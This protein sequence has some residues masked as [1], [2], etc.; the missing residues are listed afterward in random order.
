MNRVR[1]ISP[2]MDADSRKRRN[3]VV[4]PE[5]DRGRLARHELGSALPRWQRSHRELERFRS[6]EELL[7]RLLA[8]ALRDDDGP[9]RSLLALAPEE[10]L[11]ARL[12]LAAV[13][14][15]LR[16]QAGWIA[17]HRAHVSAGTRRLRRGLGAPLLPR[18]GGDL[19]RFCLPASAYLPAAR[20]RDPLPDA[21]GA[22]P[23]RAA[24][25]PRPAGAARG[26][27]ART[28]RPRRRHRAAAHPPAC[29]PNRPR[30]RR[31]E[32]VADID[33]ERRP[34]PMLPGRPRLC[35]A[36]AYTTVTLLTASPPAL[37]ATDLNTVIGNLELWL[38]GLLASL[39]TVFLIIGAV[40]YVDGRRRPGPARE[41]KERDH[42]RGARLR[43]RALRPGRDHDHPADRR[44]MTRRRLAIARR[45]ACAWRCS[46]PLPR[47][48]PPP[49]G[50]ADRRRRP[51]RHDA[52]GVQVG[53][54]PPSS[55]GGGQ[56]TTVPGDQATQPAFWDL[57]GRVRQA[58]DDWFSGLVLDALTPT[59]A[60]VGKTVLSTPALGRNAQIAGLWQ[61]SLI[62]ADSLLVLFL[63]VGAGLAMSHETLQTPL[64]AQGPAARGSPSPAIVINASLSLVDQLGG[65]A[66]ALA[67]AF[68]GDGASAAGGR[69][70]RSRASSSARSPAAASSSRCSG[71][72][73]PSPR[74]R[75]SSLYL[76]R[77][78][79]VVVL[80]CA[81]PARSC[82]RHLFP[83]TEG[84]AHLWWRAL[85]AAF[86]VQVSQA[87]LLAA[88]VRVFFAGGGAGPRPLGRRQRRSTCC[89]ASA[90]STCS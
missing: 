32:P 55:T 6:P 14:P 23:G 62:A 21:D 46:G 34:R 83:Q 50:A 44:R 78:A 38:T 29:P 89:S 80:V 87:L 73:A 90:C 76:L 18:L 8:D 12:V 88:C 36:L 7:A 86:G 11:A 42:E 31:P 1:M 51:G 71:S 25:G 74:S 4:E 3:K 72:P 79:I 13:L 64:R 16:Q 49:A 66:N 81:A 69:A 82:S 45:A 58:I 52:P 75:C 39:A 68:L 27:R 84:L 17:C 5:R 53:P 43:L 35:A 20:R 22:R 56:T 33:A 41:G 28:A 26:R 19:L 60:L 70:P 65:V 77:A 40:R 10:P 24:R 57:P 37:A 48:P 15:A 67:A 63:L 54:P 85:A 9:L 2:V 61:I 59:L 30:E 47:S